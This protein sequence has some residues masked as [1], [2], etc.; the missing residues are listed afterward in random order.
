MCSDTRRRKTSGGSLSLRRV[1]VQD[2]PMQL[3]HHPQ[4]EENFSCSVSAQSIGIEVFT[5][6][7]KVA[8]FLLCTRTASTITRISG[9]LI[10]QRILGTVLTPKSAPLL[11]RDIGRCFCASFFCYILSLFCPLV[12]PFGNTS[13]S[14]LAVSTILVSLVSIV[15]IIYLWPSSKFL[16]STLSE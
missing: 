12:W 5:D 16:C 4:A 1:L 8:S 7:S 10:S 11:A 15:S 14:C 9:A 3:S 6:V 13:S 2:R